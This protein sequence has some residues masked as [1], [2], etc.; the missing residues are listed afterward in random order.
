M[1]KKIYVEVNA[2]FD[3]HGTMMPRAVIWRDGRVFGID[4]VMDI[5]RAASTKAGGVGQRYTCMVRGKR[6][7]LWY[8]DPRWFV[9]AIDT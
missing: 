3:T 9:E 8:E 6:T 5:R 2:H 1:T 7:Y 4:R